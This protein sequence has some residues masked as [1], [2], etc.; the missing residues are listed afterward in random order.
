LIHHVSVIERVPAV[1]TYE[2]RHQA[3]RRGD[4]PTEAGDER[5]NDRKEVDREEILHGRLPLRPTLRAEQVVQLIEDVARNANR[6]TGVGHEP[7][8]GVLGLA[9]SDKTLRIG[10]DLGKELGWHLAEIRD[11]ALVE[12]GL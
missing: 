7:S 1:V 8:V 6:S 11:D 4:S 2:L 3:L 5:V 10:A 9:G 12:D